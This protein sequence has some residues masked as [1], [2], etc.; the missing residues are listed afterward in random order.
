MMSR[1][2]GLLVFA[3]MSLP[4]SAGQSL[5]QGFLNDPLFNLTGQAEALEADHLVVDG[6]ATALYGIDAP[7]RIQPCVKDGQEFACGVQA[8]RTLSDILAKGPVTCEEVRDTTSLRRR[9]QRYARCTIGDLDVAAEMVRAGMAMAMADQSDEY[10]A[11][12][13][14]AKAAKTGLWAA[15]EFTP[16][17]EWEEQRQYDR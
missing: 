16:P 10:V 8:L 13:E 4:F 7:L 6:Q 5:A 11:L 14:E 15:D 2:L 3:G 1:Y 9:M 12:E 17:W